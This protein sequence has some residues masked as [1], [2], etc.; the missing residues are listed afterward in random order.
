MTLDDRPPPD[1]AALRL[2]TR[3]R[4]E[5]W[6]LTGPPGRAYGFARDLVATAP[7]IARFWGGRM[8]ARV[9][10]EPPTD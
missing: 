4:I 7:L 6:A 2:S 1:P 9:L 5:A 10:R 3:E 8:R